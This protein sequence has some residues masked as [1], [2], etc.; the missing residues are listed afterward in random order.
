LRDL[1]QFAVADQTPEPV[2]TKDKRVSLFQGEGTIGNV[3]RNFPTASEGGGKNVAL[4][5]GL[6]VF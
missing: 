6:S 3:R 5:V 4:G 1:G 2:G